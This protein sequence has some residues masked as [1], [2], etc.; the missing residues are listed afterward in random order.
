MNQRPFW[1]EAISEIGAADELPADAVS[2]SFN[3]SDI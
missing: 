1:S 3:V 2:E